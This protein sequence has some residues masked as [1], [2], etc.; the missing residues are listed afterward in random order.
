MAGIA[1]NVGDRHIWK[2]EST[3][4]KEADFLGHR[5]GLEMECSL[6]RSLGQFDG[7][8]LVILRIMEHNEERG[9]EIEPA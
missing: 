5:M 1:P 4:K 8:G 2:N 3:L 6:G 7:H 9:K